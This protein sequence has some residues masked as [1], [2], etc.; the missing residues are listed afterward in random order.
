MPL[1]FYPYSNIMVIGATSTGKTT[2]VLRIIK[3]RLIIDM[4]S[5]IFYCYGAKQP[6]MDT[7]NR[8]SSNPKID[9]VEGLHL[10]VINSFKGPKL[11]VIDD[12]VTEQSKALS[13]H[14]I[15]DSHHKKCTTIYISHSVFQ[16]NDNYKMITNNCQYML[17]MKNKRNFL[18][19]KILATQI[20]GD[21]GDRIIEAY[22]YIDC[23][24]PLVLYFHPKV[25]DQLLVVADYFKTCPSVFL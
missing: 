23:Y 4:P 19:V 18:Q 8:D 16:N 10:D 15:R 14:F 2:A 13:N 5:K 25:P 24:E 6:F 7:W 12:L 20:L 22:K 11:L 9:F 3:E 1:K 17:I 21:R